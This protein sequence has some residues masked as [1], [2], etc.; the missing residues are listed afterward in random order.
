MVISGISIS[1]INETGNNRDE[2]IPRVR[3]AINAI[4]TAMGRW[5]RNFIMLEVQGLEFRVYG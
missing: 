1:G 3:I 5:I 2:T 4:I